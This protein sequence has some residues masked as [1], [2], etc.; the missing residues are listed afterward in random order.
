MGPIE[1]IGL[2]KMDFL[3]LR[4]LDVIEDAVEIIERSRGVELDIEAI[5]LDDAEDLR[6]ARPRRLDRRLPARVRRACATRCARCARPSSTTSSRSVSLYR[7]GAMRFIDDY[8]RGKRDPASVRYAG[9]APAPDHRGHLRLLH[10]PGAADGDRQADGRL[11]PRP[12][13]TTCARRSA[14]RSAT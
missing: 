2:L 11:Q 14:R 7:P 5:P 4:N 10:L 6:D 8:A 13:R 1:E 12:R 3:G 9:P